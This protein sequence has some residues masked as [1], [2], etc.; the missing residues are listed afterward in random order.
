LDV[1]D[2]GIHV[3]LPSRF[4][5]LGTITKGMAMFKNAFYASVLLIALLS[6]LHALCAIPV[7]RP[8]QSSLSFEVAAIKPTPL[9]FRGRYMTM[10]GAHQLQIKGYTVRFLVSA[11]YNLPPRAI[12]GG[13][14]WIDV[15]RYDVLAATPGETRP[16]SEEQAAMIRTLL[17]DRFHLSFHT[18]PKE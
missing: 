18:E 4:E 13:P 5:E 17:T 3:I 6:P 11:A 1:V 12:T 9:D 2:D 14:D 10:Q 8:V 7:S 15:D 16:S